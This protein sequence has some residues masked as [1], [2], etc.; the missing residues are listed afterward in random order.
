METLMLLNFGIETLGDIVEVGA[1]KFN[2]RPVLVYDGR[3]F[4]FGEQR[5]RIYRLANA[6]HKMGVRRQDRVAILAQNSNAYVEAYCAGEVSGFITVAINYRLSASEIEHIVKDSA[7]RVL[8]FDEEYAAIASGIRAKYPEISHTIVIGKSEFDGAENYEALLAKSS[9]DTPKLRS[10]PTDIAYLIYTSGTTGRPKGAMLDHA[11]QLGFIQMQAIEMSLRSTDTMLLVM[12]FYHIGAKCNYLMTSFVG[13]SVILHRS[14]DIRAVSADILRHKVTTIHLAPV[15]VKDLLDLPDFNKSHYASLRL[16]Q[17]ASGPMAVAQLRQ[18]IAA[19]GPIL[20]QIY[21]MTESG[22][23]TILHPHQHVLDGSPE[24]VRRLGSAGQEA[25]GYRVRVVQPDGSDCEPEEQGEIWVKGPGV[26]VGYWKNHPATLD[27]IEDGW[28]KSGDIGAFDKD[29][30]LFVLDR[31]KD[32]ILSG[33][34]NIYPRE[35][36]EALY[37]HP[38]VAE[39]AVIGIPDSRWGESV[40][41][42]VVVAPGNAVNE[43]DLIEHCRKHIASYKKPKSVEFVGALPRLPNKKIDKK[44][45]RAPY[46]DG[47]TRQVN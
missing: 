40:K 33:G 44:Q 47:R 35:V 32:M 23:G 19:F 4:S 36:E 14:Y 41:A 34:E 31:K 10:R 46:W 20:A 11:G 16:I 43:G 9:D 12:P 5:S 24:W 38:A 17:Y 6:L 1:S 22:L 30:F 27:A 28:M 7:P 45:L 39:A 13:A 26:M 15:M 29:R 42:F 25:L 18:A 8:I 21:G 37:A 2:A 3:S